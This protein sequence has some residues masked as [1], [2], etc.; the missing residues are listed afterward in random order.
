[1]TQSQGIS[2]RVAVADPSAPSHAIKPNADGSVNIVG[3]AGDGGPVS[4]ANGADVT[5]GA[6]ANT[7]VIDPTA[8]ATV[9]SI[10]KGLLA[11][12]N[13]SYETVAAGVTAQ[14]LGGAGAA[15]D[16]LSGVLVVPATTAPGVVTILDNAISIPVFVGGTLPS[17]I[18]FWVNIGAHS[19]SGAWKIST[20]A[21]VSAFCVGRFT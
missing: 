16:Y 18:P 12:T 20:G 2:T 10:L 7:A 9:V 3:G 1:M 14:V 5:Q 6:I 17:V 21:N 11:L 8:S 19:A 4:V 15:G 13:G